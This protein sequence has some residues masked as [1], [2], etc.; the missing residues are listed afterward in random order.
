M[1][2][3]VRAVSDTPRTKRDWLERVVKELALDTSDPFTLLFANACALLDQRDQLKRE[4]E[5]AEYIGNDLAHELADARQ[6]ARDA[7][8]HNDALKDAIDSY[9]RLLGHA[10]QTYAEHD[11]RTPVLLTD[12]SVTHTLHAVG[13]ARM[14]DND[15]AILVML[16]RRPTDDELRALHDTLAGR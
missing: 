1:G 3:V 7:Y 2:R 5:Q 9:R 11:L 12:R 15:K 13:V 16:E 6:L 4:L 10:A 14:H 8:A